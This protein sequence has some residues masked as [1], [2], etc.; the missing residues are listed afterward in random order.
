M[1][2][3]IQDTAMPFTRPPTPKVYSCVVVIFSASGDLTKRKFVPALYDLAHDG[4]AG[5]VIVLGVWQ[6]HV[7][8]KKF[9]DQMLIGVSLENRVRWL[10]RNG[11]LRL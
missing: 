6:D 10:R 3:L 8:E 11:Q 9:R 1:S 5:D 7:T 2:V 4:G